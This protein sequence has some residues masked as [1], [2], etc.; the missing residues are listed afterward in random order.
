MGIEKRIALGKAL[1]RLREAQN[2]KPIDVAAEVRVTTGA[3][4]QWEN[5]RMAPNVTN[6]QVLAALFG[7]ESINAL[8]ED[9][10]SG[11]AAAK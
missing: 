8:L 9:A 5:G 10:W 3:I 1:R 2:L 7:F 4:S 6:L 11:L